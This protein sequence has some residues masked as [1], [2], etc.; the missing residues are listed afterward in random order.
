MNQDGLTAKV[1][2]CLESI[3]EKCV[4][5]RRG[6]GGGP[7]AV[8]QKGCLNKNKKSQ[9]FALANR[10]F[11]RGRVGLAISSNGLYGLD[12]PPYLPELI[13]FNMWFL[14][15]SQTS[16]LIQTSLKCCFSLRKKQ[17]TWGGGSW[18][19]SF[20]CLKFILLEKLHE[21][22]IKLTFQ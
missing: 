10:E 1:L 6:H 5:E 2:I 18:R 12:H 15:S 20:P 7:A 3:H 8:L 13:Y 21:I 11:L 9:S 16:I 17:Y 4:E 19:V 22:N 14:L